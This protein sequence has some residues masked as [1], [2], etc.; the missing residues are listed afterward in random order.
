M[1][2][3]CDQ[4]ASWLTNQPTNQPTNQLDGAVILEKLIV[5]QLVK[6]SA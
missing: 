2:H 1:V 5:I 4:L 3:V 6:L